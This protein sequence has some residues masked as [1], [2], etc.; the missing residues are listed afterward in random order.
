MSPRNEIMSLINSYA[1]TFDA[2][3]RER[4]A[5]FFEHG[6]WT[7]EGSPPNHG[8]DEV[9]AATAGVQIFDDGTTR[10]KH[11]TTNVELDI[12]EDAGTATGQCYLSVFQQTDD[13]PLQ[14]IFVGHYFD[15]FERVDGVWRFSRRVI[16]NPLVGDLSGH[17]AVP[18][19]VVP[20][21]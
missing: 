16:R 4:F 12:D 17:L 10:T 21:A 7:V 13:F 15:E 3:D 5:G 20:G 2:G 11:L 8:T 9:L 1:F 19:D 14:P 6:E 18:S